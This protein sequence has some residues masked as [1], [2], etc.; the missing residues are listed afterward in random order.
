M[1]KTEEHIY[2]VHSC[3]RKVK[4]RLKRVQSPARHKFVQRLAGGAIVVRRKR[5]ATITGSQLKAYLAEIKKANEEGRVEVRLVTGELV[6]LDTMEAAPKAPSPPAPKPP[7]DSAANDK[8]FEAGVGEK[9]PKY[10]GG[11]AIDEHAEPPS[12][13]TMP[14]GGEPEE[15]DDGPDPEKDPAA[16]RRRKKKKGS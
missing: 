13:L 3:V 7:L 10:R 15:V 9:I 2:K 1:A 16:A 6:D 14:D 4:T 8:T 12:P 11:K 5:P